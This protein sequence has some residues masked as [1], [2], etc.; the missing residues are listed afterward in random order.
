MS[1]EK[2]AGL[3]AFTQGN[4][5]AAIASLELAFN[6]DP[7]DYETC[8]YLGG[9]YGQAQRHD[10]SVRLLTQAVTLQPSNAQARFNLGV[11]LE[12]AG[13][14]E[15]AVTV[16]QQAVQLQ[17]SYPKATEAIQ[18]IRGAMMPVPQLNRSQPSAVGAPISEPLA[19]LN[20]PLATSSTQMPQSHLN[21]PPLTASAQMPQ[22][23]LTAPAASS[24]ALMPS[25]GG[26]PANQSFTPTANFSQTALKSV[27]S[28]PSLGI[29]IL[30]GIVLILV[31]G[32]GFG[33]ASV[34]MGFRIPFLTLAIGYI[35]GYAVLKACGGFQGTGPGIIAAV[36]AIVAAGLGLMIMYLNS[37]ILSPISI[38]I[39]IYAGVRAFKIASGN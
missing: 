29:A 39:L 34:A 19:S 25:T 23:N 12:H 21:A 36:S 10:D 8:L 33:F 13:W 28:E 31:C 16:F 27:P 3:A 18:R 37:V 6:A 17:P 22:F 4:L 35:M 1:A 9:A 20:A 11:A 5:A 30:V 14:L 38:I 26:M 7:N 2:D 15:Q 24:P 32:L